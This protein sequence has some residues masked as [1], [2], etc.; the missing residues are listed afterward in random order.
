MAVTWNRAVQSTALS[1]DV[2]SIV[3]VPLTTVQNRRLSS[4]AR[5]TTTVPGHVLSRCTA[6]RKRA[7]E[8]RLSG[9]HEQSFLTQTNPSPQY[10]VGI[11]GQSA[12]RQ[13]GIERT[14]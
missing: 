6:A 2:L 14:G 1:R 4:P 11:E 9:T 7:V 12:M 5:P 13:G 8:A 3:S 10:A